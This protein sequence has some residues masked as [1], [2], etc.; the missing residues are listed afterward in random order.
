MPNDDSTYPY[1]NEESFLSIPSGTSPGSAYHTG[2]TPPTSR[3][4]PISI[5]GGVPPSR[6][7]TASSQSTH[8]AQPNATPPRTG[9]FSVNGTPP[10]SVFG[11]QQH[12]RG[13]ISGDQFRPLEHRFV[14]SSFG[15]SVTCK[16]CSEPVK[17][18]AMFCEVC[19]LICHDRCKYTTPCT[20][21]SNSYHQ[22]L[23]DVNQS[24]VLPPLT[25]PS[26]SPVPDSPLSTPRSSTSL[27][28]RPRPFSEPG[29]SRTRKFSTDINTY[30]H[31]VPALPTPTSTP[32]PGP[33]PTPQPSASSSTN[34]KARTRKISKVF[35]S[36]TQGS[37]G[38]QLKDLASRNRSRELL[39]SIESGGFG[40]GSTTRLND[41]YTNTIVDEPA[42]LTRSS[43]KRFGSISSTSDLA[44]TLV[45]NTSVEPGDSTA[46]T[47]PRAGYSA[48][49]PPASETSSS[50]NSIDVGE[51]QSRKRVGSKVRGGNGEECRIS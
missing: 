51:R 30:I 8:G 50:R 21:A 43:S 28:S 18:N 20:G 41:R 29:K 40:N 38:N 42:S 15:R 26:T 48:F 44:S 11:Q 36:V 12:V 31:P 34:F 24:P 7:N 6:S 32:V 23:N 4:Y 1:H 27:S 13:S 47:T 46:P 22:P 37:L 33:A 5:A 3:N 39:D 14:K 45:V 2:N 17:R 16:V 10:R 9:W 25:I 35:T 49:P 19:T